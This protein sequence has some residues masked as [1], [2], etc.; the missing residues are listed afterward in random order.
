MVGNLGEENPP[1]PYIEER[2]GLNY[3]KNTKYFLH[4]LGLTAIMFVVIIGWVFILIPFAICGF[5][6]GIAIA[7]GILVYVMGWIN[8]WL[9]GVIW[10]TERLKEEWWGPLVHGTLLFI[11]LL[12]LSM[13]WYAVQTVIPEL[14]DWPYLLISIVVFLIYCF[15]DGVAAY[16]IGNMFTSTFVKKSPPIAPTEM[17]PPAPPEG[18]QGPSPP[19][20]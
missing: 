7:F 19:S 12:I 14:N 20:A 13:P 9:M 10:G 16:Y 5:C 17:T 4:G 6:F 11:V 2:K 1:N 3:S 18:P 15:I 8:T